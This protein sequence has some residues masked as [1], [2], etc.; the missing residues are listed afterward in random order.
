[1]IEKIYNY[2]YPLLT[3]EERVSLW[4][5]SLKKDRSYGVDITH[6]FLD[7]INFPKRKFFLK[8]KKV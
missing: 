3:L 1:M 4:C 7:D 6:Q 2:L 8:I 5:L